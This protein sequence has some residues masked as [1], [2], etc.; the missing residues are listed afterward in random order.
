MTSL[1]DRRSIFSDASRSSEICLT[2]LF[3]L[4]LMGLKAIRKN[5]E[6]YENLKLDDQHWTDE[7]LITAM[8]EHPILIN[9]PFVVTT[10]GTRLCR[11][12]EIVLDILSAPQLH[13]FNK[14]DGEK[15]IDNEGNRIK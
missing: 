15:I 3:C 4:K 13:A 9:R 1:K 2:A 6:P 10:L 12:S 14:E 11:P 8:L 7:T 5:V